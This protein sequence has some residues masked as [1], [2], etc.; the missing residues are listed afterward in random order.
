ML[1][2]QSSNKRIGDAVAARVGSLSADDQGAGQI[3]FVPDDVRCLSAKRPRKDQNEEEDAEPRAEELVGEKG[4]PKSSW[5]DAAQQSAKASRSF[6]DTVQKYGQKMQQ[7]SNAMRNQID[8]S[9]S[10]NSNCKTEIMICTNRLQCLSEILVGTE[11]SFAD[12][13]VNLRQTASAS[14][15]VNSRGT[16][17]ESA[18]GHLGTPCKDHES[19]YTLQQFKQM[20]PAFGKVSVQE[21]PR[22]EKARLAAEVPTRFSSVFTMLAVPAG[23]LQMDT[24][25]RISTLR[26]ILSSSTGQGPW[27]QLATQQTPTC[28]TSRRA[29]A[30]PSKSSSKSSARATCPLSQERPSRFVRRAVSSTSARSCLALW[31]CATPTLLAKLCKPLM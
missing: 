6:E 3:D 13:C 29:A 19:L 18:V 1:S 9:R 10:C 26:T 25:C 24:N 5:F 12:Y 15:S 4:G 23:A 16:A 22:R 17:N 30:R 8:L 2:G 20:A 14:C 7:Q 27:Q 11:K 31:A 21:Q 28:L